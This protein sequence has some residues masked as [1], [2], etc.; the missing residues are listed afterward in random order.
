MVVDEESAF[1]GGGGDGG[2]PPNVHDVGGG[3][4]LGQLLEALCGLVVD[5][6]WLCVALLVVVVVLPELSEECVLAGQ[7]DVEHE[8]CEFQM[9]LGDGGGHCALELV[10]RLLCSDDLWYADGHELVL[11]ALTHG[12]GDVV[13]LAGGFVGFGCNDGVDVPD[14]PFESFD[15]SS[16]GVESSRPRG[17]YPNN[18]YLGNIGTLRGDVVQLMYY[19]P[20]ADGGI[21]TSKGSTIF[22]A[23][24][25]IGFMLKTN[26]W[27]QRGKDYAV[28]GN[29]TSSYYKKQN[30]WASSTDGLSFAPDG[31]KCPNDDGEARSAKF[32]YKA[33]NGN[34]YVVVSFEDACDDKDYDDLMFALNP[35][36]AFDFSDVAQIESKRVTVEGVYGF[37]DKWPEAGDYDKGQEVLLHLRS[38]VG[39]K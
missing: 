2:E 31:G 5:D 19:P 7:Q 35:A 22:P 33:P 18:N 29:T 34:E 3:E 27:G 13:V 15:F 28:N 23:G 11:H 1:V 8:C 37:E 21:D 6:T 17:S 36:N 16:Q 26:A 9:L 4:L 30:I 25:K 24:T 12:D 32:A 14:E 20:T 38:Q 39:R 10:P